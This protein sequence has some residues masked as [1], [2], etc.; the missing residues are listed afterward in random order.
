MLD[1]YGQKW[2][3]TIE[4]FETNRLFAHSSNPE[5][6]SISSGPGIF[7]TFKSQVNA[8]GQIASY[9]S[10]CS[11]LVPKPVAQPKTDW[12]SG[13]MASK[14]KPKR[15]HAPKQMVAAAP[16]CSQPGRENGGGPR[17][18]QLPS[19]CSCRPPMIVLWSSN[20]PEK[21]Q[22]PGCL[23]KSKAPELDGSA[24]PSASCFQKFIV[25]RE[26]Q[27]CSSLVPRK[28]N[29]EHVTTG[30]RTLLSDKAA[31]QN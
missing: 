5:L 17:L 30:A 22:H 19:S 9:K 28:G 27:V 31:G 10:A 16:A 14:A 18:F 26:P 7:N 23:A 13:S 12:R 8:Y 11:K 1:D 29:Q 25:A 20:A 24:S 6:E 3:H 21:K 2:F 4:Q 15:Q